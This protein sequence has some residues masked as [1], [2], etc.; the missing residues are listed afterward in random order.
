MA[1]SSGSVMELKSVKTLD[2][3][4]LLLHILQL[5]QFQLE[6]QF[7]EPLEVFAVPIF[8]R[9]NGLLLALPMNSI[10][11]EIMLSGVD[12]SGDQLLGPC[13]VVSVSL[14]AEQEDGTEVT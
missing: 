7:V 1:T 13:T 14:A 9:K 10:P 12:P 11:E 6:D 8:T 2:K 3:G 4:P 5:P